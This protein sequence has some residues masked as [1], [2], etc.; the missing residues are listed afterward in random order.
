MATLNSKGEAEPIILLPL[1]RRTRE[2]SRGGPSW[3]H[4]PQENVVE[5]RL[6]ENKA[7]SPS[8]HFRLLGHRQPVRVVSNRVAGPW[9]L[10]LWHLRKMCV[11]LDDLYARPSRTAEEHKH[12]TKRHGGSPFPTLAGSVA[13]ISRTGGRCVAE[14]YLD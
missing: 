7:G 9:H 4:L 6:A 5:M 12:V 3:V 1:A 10:W 8:N 14:R 11:V 2:R 13:F